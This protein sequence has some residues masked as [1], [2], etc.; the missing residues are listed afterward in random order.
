MKIGLRGANMSQT[1]IN[2]KLA[3]FIK[4]TN[5][6]LA[7]SLLI[8][9]GY[10]QGYAICYSAMDSIGKL[11]WWK[12]ALHAVATWD[13]N[14]E[15]LEKEVDLPQQD[16]R[17]TLR[18]V[19][20]KVL[21]FI[22]FQQS[23]RN[24]QT[25]NFL[26]ADQTQETIFK[27]KG[28]LEIVGSDK[29]IKKIADKKSVEGT[30]TKEQI[31]RLL[32]EKMM[33]GKMTNISSNNHVVSVFYHDPHWGIYNPNYS[34]SSIE[35]MQKYYGT[36]EELV[37]EIIRVQSNSIKIQICS[38]D[39]KMKV[40]FPDFPPPTLSIENLSLLVGNSD[41]GKLINKE[42]E[43]KPE[44]I[45][46]LLVSK[47]N[48]GKMGLG[49]IAADN[50]SVIPNMLRI[51][52]KSKE[53]LGEL[54]KALIAQ[55]SD[56]D[57]FINIQKL[58]ALTPDPEGKMP[59]TD[60]IWMSIDK[61]LLESAE[62]KIT[63]TPEEKANTEYSACL[64]RY[65]YISMDGFNVFRSTITQHLAMKAK[66]SL[67]LL[68]DIISETKEG[69]EYLAR[70]LS[71]KNNVGLTD[72]HVIA[73]CAPKSLPKY[74]RIIAK[75]ENGMQIINDVLRMRIGKNSP[76]SGWSGL[77]IIYKF[78]PATYPLALKYKWKALP[79]GTKKVII[80]ASAIAALGVFAY[81][82]RKPAATAGSLSSPTPF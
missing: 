79:R 12:A 62:E 72:L 21:D 53:S 24:K 11:P 73:Q 75:A 34:H 76:W 25:N 10:C 13:L 33:S 77:K 27:E 22:V 18:D 40:T 19:F 41:F 3:K 5:H 60:R 20:T 69:P 50:S 57:E 32:D 47:N 35:S 68:L 59:L 74:L 78:A 70:A 46:K 81:V 9:G 38:L 56:D 48:K 52:A 37:D 55:D 64:L 80:G 82:R 45:I 39:E 51:I 16:G 23:L 14:P 6:G 58:L 42:T 66:E 65:S 29:K 28:E 36:K 54:V 63:L 26:L 15:S 43:G 4:S 17:Q 31:S 61:L 8:A 44:E 7:M 2:R 30:F 1:V 49:K 67:P 71:L